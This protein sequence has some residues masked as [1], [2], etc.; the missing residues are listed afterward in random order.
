[1]VHR[2]KTDH[3][4]PSNLSPCS[5]SRVSFLFFTKPLQRAHEQPSQLL[6]A[7]ARRREA[8]DHET[9]R[10]ALLLASGATVPQDRHD[11]L[12]TARAELAIIVD[13]LGKQKID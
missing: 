7:M 3:L 1:M 6:A 4:I 5:R 12:C 2:T 11:R 10:Q 13:A 8:I 9:K